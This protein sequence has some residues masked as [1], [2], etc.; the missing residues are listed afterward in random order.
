MTDTSCPFCRKIESGDYDEAVEGIA[1]IFE[2]L[3]PVVPGHLLVVPVN[4][5]KSAAHDVYGAA[6]AM[7]V[8]A[9]WIAKNN[10]EANIIT[11]IG[12][13]ATQSVEHTHLHIV[14]R[15]KGDN[16]QLPWTGQVKPARCIPEKNVHVN[17]H[18][19]C[20]LR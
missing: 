19:G 16:L 9:E 14:P 10:L 5:A 17:P 11:S 15:R 4:H 18:R 6:D 1:V 8:A 20:F 13:M 3:D 12:P 2:P 7:F